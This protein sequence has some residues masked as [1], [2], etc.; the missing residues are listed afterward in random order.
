MKEVADKAI[1]AVSLFFTKKIPATI[2]YA[3]YVSKSFAVDMASRIAEWFSENVID[4]AKFG[5]VLVKTAVPSFL[6]GFFIGGFAFAGAQV[7]KTVSVLSDKLSEK[8]ARLA[9]L[10]ASVVIGIIAVT[11]VIFWNFNTVA[12]S[13]NTNGK[14]VGYIRSKADFAAVSAKMSELLVDGKIDADKEVTLGYGICSKSSVSN[15]E[16]LADDVLLAQD[17]VAKAFGLF[18]D[19]KYIT[20]ATSEKVLTDALECRKNE[21]SEAGTTSAKILNDIS[22]KPV[23]SLCGDGKVSDLVAKDMI[24]NT[25]VTDL[26]VET[27][28]TKTYTTELS[29]NT[30]TKNDATK[31]IGYKRISVQGKNGTA[32]ITAQCVLVNGKEVSRDI[33][34]TEVV[35]SPVDQVVV[36]GT[37]KSGA[38]SVVL[39]LSDKGKTFLWPIKATPNMYVSAYCGDGRG[40]TGIDITGP[41]G[42][43]IYA[44]AA[45]RVSYAGYANGFGKLVIID[46]GNNYSTAYGHMCKINVSVGQYVEAGQ[47]I[48]LCGH[49]GVATGN[50]VH[51]EVR[52]YDTPINPAP[53]LGLNH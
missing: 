26:S 39:S 52:V 42:T 34:E 7:K 3:F 5:A 31:V 35:S 8:L 14:C 4:N 28:T 36:C 30:V 41:E 20:S 9:V 21:F 38:S 12:V 10:T 17:N 45:G 47:T 16:E 46:H 15:G 6:K 1:S 37:S 50:H 24:R 25:A 22:I 33:L 23:F 40:H 27:V 19:G 32:V 2:Q 18:V 53:Y 29:Y 44:A 51:F 13:V 49:E 11:S 43:P 48:A